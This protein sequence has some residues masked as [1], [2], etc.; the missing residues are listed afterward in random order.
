MGNGASTPSQS[1]LGTPRTPLRKKPHATS[2]EN[3]TS[4]VS[5]TRS[6]MRRILSQA[7]ELLKDAKTPDKVYFEKLTQFNLASVTG[8]KT[9]SD[10][11]G[12]AK[13]LSVSIFFKYVK[14]V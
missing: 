11:K 6:Q 7:D 9:P 14:S 1:P 10:P 8:F 3:S 13:L 5:L 2:G 12:D 4:K